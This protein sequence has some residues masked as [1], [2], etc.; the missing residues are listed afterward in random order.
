[1]LNRLVRWTSDERGRPCIEWAADIRHKEIIVKQLG[2]GSGIRAS[3]V[4]TPGV[5]KSAEEILGS[6]ELDGEATKK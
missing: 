1:M 6:Q 3:S 4:K 2:L 5:K